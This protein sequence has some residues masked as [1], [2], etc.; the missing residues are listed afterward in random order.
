MHVFEIASC[1]PRAFVQIYPQGR[2]KETECCG[3]GFLSLKIKVTKFQS[4]RVSKVRDVNFM[5]FLVDVDFTY[6]NRKNCLDG[7]SGLFGPRP[8][9]PKQN[10]GFSKF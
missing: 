2:T 8:S 7:S 9:P 3:L 6:S 5:F 4:V 10:V 1:A